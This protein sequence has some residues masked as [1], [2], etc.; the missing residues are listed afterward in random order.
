MRDIKSVA[1]R[2]CA[3]AALAA[4]VSTRAEMPEE[5][6]R[7]H[8]NLYGVTGLIDMPSAEM[9]PDAQISLT[10]GYFGGYMRNTLS[11]QIFPGVEAAFRYSILTDFLSAGTEDLYDRSFDIKLRLIRE[12]EIWPNVVVGFQDFLGTGVYSSEYIA[13]TKRFFEGSVVLT[14]GVGWGRLSSANDVENVFCAA[15]DSMCDR[16]DFDGVGGEVNFGRF[17][18]GE[19]MGFFGGVQWDTPIDGL[20][21]KAEL[22]SDAYTREELSGN[23]DQNIPVNFGIEYRPIENIEV[24][25]YYMYG[26]EF[27]VRITISGNP[28][29][30][31]APFDTEP[32][33]LPV[34]HRSLQPSTA[35]S[36]GLGKTIDL[37]TGAVPVTDY[38]EAGIKKV[39]LETDPDGTRRA[40]AVLPASADDA[41]PAATAT[42][43][44]ADLQLIDLVTYVRPDGQAICTVALRPAGER[45]IRA[46]RRAATDFSTDWYDDPA[47]RERAVEALGEALATD[48]VGLF[49]IELFAT[50]ARVYIEN[51]RF[52]AMPRAI[53]R[54]A[55]ALSRSMPPSV[56]LF[57]IVPVENGLPVATIAI[58][59]TDVEDFV[60]QSD[61]ATDMWSAATLAE[62]P[63]PQWSAVEGVDS[64]F[65]RASYSIGPYVP[66]NFFDPDSPLR[67]DLQILALGTVEVAPGISA[68]AEITQRIV[69][70]LDDIERDPDSDLPPVRTDLAEY[71]RTDTPVIS[72]LTADY[73]TKLDDDIYARFSGGLFER[74]FGG[75]G[76]EVLWKPVD[77][78]WGIGGEI[79]WVQQRDFEGYFGFRNYDVFTGHASFYWD[80]GF[81]GI[82]TQIDAGRYLAGDWGGTFSLS[83]RFANGWEIGAFFTLT[84]VPFDE[85]GEGSFDKGI[86]LTIPFNWVLP[87]DGRSSY[88]TTIRPVTRDGGQRLIVA[89]R[90]YPTVRDN[91]RGGLKTRWGGFWE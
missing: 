44:D 42:G 21:L 29:S 24:G 9:Q 91:D 75:V 52:F 37:V 71:F 66:I 64:L 89:N 19:K 17:F 22:S 85:F 83:R 6:P 54:T 81:Y 32:S 11:A 60:D 53:G 45:A 61:G 76:A 70:N 15:I 33:T 90:L 87:F 73:V 30:P 59:R 47:N 10:S 56:E 86:T 84:D 40:Q 4:P 49:G 12:S 35:P 13:A 58:T 2:L 65:P 28:F 63:K 82:S 38:R 27:G 46:A 3:C 67:A 50:R 23:F 34:R 8:H 72:R 18:R 68:S 31:P 80:T 1:V 88:S 41:C 25:A 43:I 16:D 36:V 39:T 74:M 5:P 26:S 78:S 69:G 14:G 48:G 7:P 57:E 55:R 20:A 79:N 77:Q 51:R 62:A